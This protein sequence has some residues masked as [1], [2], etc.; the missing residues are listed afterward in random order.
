MNFE[1]SVAIYWFMVTVM[2]S[3]VFIT[4]AIFLIGL[5]ERPNVPPT[6]KILNFK[7]YMIG[8]GGVGKTSL[9][10]YLSGAPDWTNSHH[11]GETPGIRTTNIYWP[12]RIQNQ[13]V[14]F[15]LDLWDSGETASKKYS[16]ILPV[17][18]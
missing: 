15:Q 11:Q 3:F 18:R 2:Y 12:A 4:S 10:T 16:H 7:L 9:V 13:L 5:L 1:F 6:I 14:L 8:K 17:S